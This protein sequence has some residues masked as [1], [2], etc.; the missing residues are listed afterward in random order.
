MRREDLAD[1]DCGIAQSLG[2]LGDWWTFLIVRDIAGGATRFD[3]LQ[4]GLGISR[5][6]LTERLAG[7]VAD[8]VLDRRAYSERPPRHDYVL[9]TKGEALLPVLVALQDWGA[10]HVL[11]DG[12]VSAGIGLGSAEAHRVGDLVGHPVPA[13]TL[14]GHDG[15]P[16]SFPSGQWTVLFC[17]PGAWAPAAQGYPPGWGDI[18]GAAGCTVEA[19]AYAGLLG[20]FAAR[21]VVVHGVSTQRPD[22]QAAFAEFAELPY[23]LLSDEDL[24]LAGSLRLPTFRSGGVDRLKRATLLLDPD[25]VVRSVQAPVADPA[26]S[27]E[28][29]LRVVDDLVEA[30]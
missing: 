13:I 6:A 18:P 19:R 16:T 29:M 10:R 15:I 27:A 2:V 28:E 1:E 17:M 4:R 30:A 5:R 3:A 14:T 9:T 23:R 7:L 12:S 25:G 11:G 8:G 20:E 21:G 24:R 26:A 22:Q